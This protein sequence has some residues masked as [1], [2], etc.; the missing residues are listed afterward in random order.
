MGCGIG[1]KRDSG[2]RFLVQYLLNRD[3][4][5]KYNVFNVHLCCISLTLK[6]RNDSGEVGGAIGREAQRERESLG[7]KR[8][9]YFT[10][11]EAAL[12]IHTYRVQQNTKT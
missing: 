11:S 4:G 9:D 12:S 6:I 10:C 2:L 8:K 7:E 5:E 3:V 1:E